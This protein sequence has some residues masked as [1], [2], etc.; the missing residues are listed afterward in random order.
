MSI[1]PIKR[2]PTGIL[3]LDSI[4][5]GGFIKGDIIL[6]AGHPGTGKTTIGL[7]FLYTGARDYNEQGVYISVTE[8]TSRLKRNA[9][10]FG[11]DFS[12]LENEGLIR[13]VDLPL[14]EVPYL[15]AL[16]SGQTQAFNELVY[17]VM[18]PIYEIHAKRVVIDTVSALL[19]IC[20]SE[21]E[22]RLLLLRL[23]R[24]LMNSDATTLLLAEIPLGTQ[25]VKLTAQEFVADGVIVIEN[26]IEGNRLV[27]RLYIPKMRG[28]NHSLDCYNLYI[29]EEG[30]AISPMPAV[31]GL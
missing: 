15:V 18:R 19:S 8:P 12:T 24:E 20:K 28:T 21:G 29:T 4:I 11:W 31:R 9:L 10:R 2:I 17:N 25:E 26:V 3:G 30:V 16:E 5:E 22:A 13:F 7:Q 1:G 23:Y 6:I 14:T 27:R